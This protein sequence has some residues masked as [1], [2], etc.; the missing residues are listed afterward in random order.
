ML[1]TAYLQLPFLCA[2]S[3]FVKSAKRKPLP[4]RERE[5]GARLRSIRES[6]RLSQNE[7]AHEVGVTRERLASYEDGRAPLR[8][9]LALRICRHYIISELWLATGDGP[10]DQ[11]LDMIREPFPHNWPLD[12]TYS[13][14]FDQVLSRIYDKVARATGF[15]MNLRTTESR[16]FLYN[17]FNFLIMRWCALAKT[18][19]M[20]R[21]LLQSIIDHGYGVAE[22]LAKHGCVP[23]PAELSQYKP[24]LYRF[25]GEKPDR[26]RK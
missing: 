21:L 10:F 4:K 2:Y 16:S 19:E 1:S 23:S 8:Y 25:V 6:A 17:L 14:T 24:E 22:Y 11:Y 13:Q 3:A 26:A 20:Q 5:I 18:G 15:R 7:M 12:A 9:D